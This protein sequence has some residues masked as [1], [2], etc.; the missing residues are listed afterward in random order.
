MSYPR[1]EYSPDQPKKYWSIQEAKLKIASFCAYQERC[2]EEVRRKLAER[3]IYG[4]QAEEL[5]SD[6]IEEG[7]LNEERFT[8]AFVRGKYGLKKWGRNKIIQE[9]K[10][11]KISPN[12][13][14]SGMKE[15]EEDEYWHNLLS[16]AEKKWILIKEKDPLIK[17]FKL[18]QYLIGRGFEIDLIQMA[19]EEMISGK[20]L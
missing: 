18:Q 20:N 2:Q 12:C 11:R 5:I 16:Q 14:Q 1:K 19:I 3:G 15:I 13:I 8:K 6:L 10:F 17:R 4:E 7:F 9:L